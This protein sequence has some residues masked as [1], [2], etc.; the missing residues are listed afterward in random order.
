MTSTLQRTTGRRDVRARARVLAAF[1]FCGGVTAADAARTFPDTSRQVRITEAADDAIVAD[2][3]RLHLAPG[4]VIFTPT[5]TTLVRGALPADV[6]A[7]VQLD[8]NGDVRRIWLLAD[9][10][11]VIP[12]WQ[13]WRERP[14][15]VI[16]PAR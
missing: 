4:V 14:Q 7:R 3:A 12:W 16:V 10:E 13:F 11:I 15:G 9:D 6:V 5:N 2:G 8:L 1:V